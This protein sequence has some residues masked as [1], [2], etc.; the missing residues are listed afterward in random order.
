MLGIV[1]IS[2]MNKKYLLPIV[3]IAIIVIG[4]LSY[5][6][7]QGSPSNQ[8]GDHQPAD[9]SSGKGDSTND[10]LRQKHIIQIASSLVSS[11]LIS[12][13]TITQD[14]QNLDILATE[15]GESQ[16]L[17]DPTTSKPYQY[18]PDQ[19]SLKVGQIYFEVGGSCDNK[20]KG[21]DGVGKIVPMGNGSVA[22]N[23]M[24]ESGQYYC[25]SNI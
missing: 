7:A 19:S 23:T 16:P 9:K 11:A 13:Q 4:G 20:V 6:L 22:V 12:K 17:L 24:L 15:F 10:Q 14:Q 8:P 21:S 1:I 5:A 2:P 25:E 18:N 3:V